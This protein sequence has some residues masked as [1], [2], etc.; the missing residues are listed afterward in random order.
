MVYDRSIFG[1][2][3]ILCPFGILKVDKREVLVPDFGLSR[4]TV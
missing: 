3:L 2:A 4:K 1:L